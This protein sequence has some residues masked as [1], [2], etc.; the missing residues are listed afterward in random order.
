MSAAL[1]AAG[2]TPA[3]IAKADVAIVNTCTVTSEADHKTRKAIRKAS[4]ECAGP[5]VVTGCATAIDPEALAAL[6]ESVI[7]EPNRKLAIEKA[8]A[9]LD[10]GFEPVAAQPAHP[11]AAEGFHTRMGIKVQD[12]CNNRCAYC[13]VNRA[14]G[15]SVSMPLESVVSEVRLASESGV[16]EVVLTGINIGSYRTIAD[17]GRILKLPQLIEALLERTDIGRIRMSSIEPPDVD[18]ELI[19]LLERYRGRFCAHLHM[20][21]QS[22]CNRTL[23]AMGRLYTSEDFA[24]RVEAVYEARPDATITTDVIAG[25]PQETDEDFAQ[26]LEFCRRMRFSKIH[27]FRYSIR[28]GTPAAEMEGQIDPKIKAQRASSLHLLSDEM[29][30]DDMLRRVG[31]RELIVVE[32]GRIGMS[33]SYHEVV[34]TGDEPRRGEIL[35]LEFTGVEESRLI[36]KRV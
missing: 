13:I 12:G 8:L 18:D 7:V 25:F 17:S 16:A 6:G 15:K 29:R 30:R 19:A 14:R 26:T 36:G 4:R 22:G 21:L 9:V 31:S 27:A 28:P 35:E 11:R 34:V 1:I 20:P 33:E 3:P 5:V 32:S 23:A 10:L 2:H 24:G